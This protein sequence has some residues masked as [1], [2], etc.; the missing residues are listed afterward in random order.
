MLIEMTHHPHH[1]CSRQ[2]VPLLKVSSET[3]V[4]QS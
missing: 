2:P 3:K 4:R 1:M